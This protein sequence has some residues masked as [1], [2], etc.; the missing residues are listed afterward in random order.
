MLIW[1]RRPLLAAIFEDQTDTNPDVEWQPDLDI[2]ETPDEFLLVVGVPGV[3]D[4]DLDLSVA[5]QTLLIS[6]RRDRALPPGAVPHL[7]ESPSGRFERQVRL[8]A[9]A[10][11]TRLRVQHRGGQ[12][13]VSTPKTTAVIRS[14]RVEF[15]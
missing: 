12:L 5:G 1:R 4:E 8:P 9:T 2:Y 10:D 13:L 11:L 15:P 6:G 7:L 14:I 3:R